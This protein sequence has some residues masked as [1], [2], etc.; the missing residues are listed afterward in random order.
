[1]I[2]LKV[3]LDKH[4]YSSKNRLDMFSNS[5]MKYK[6]YGYSLKPNL[7]EDMALLQSYKGILEDELLNHTLGGK[8]CLYSKDLQ[9]LLEKVSR[10]TVS[11]NI[12]QR[13][14]LKIFSTQESRDKWVAQNPH[15][16]SR[17]RWEKLA[18]IVCDSINLDLTVI[19]N[20]MMCDITFELIR[21]IISC[22]L[23][24]ALSVREEACDLNLEVSRSEKECEIDFKLL[25]ESIDCNLTL[26][27][28]KKLVANNFTYDII[29]TVYENGCTLEIGDTIEL[30]TPI[31][32]YNVNN[33]KFN[34][35][36]DFSYVGRIG[37]NLNNSK[38]IKDPHKFINKLK[39]DYG[40]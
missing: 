33:I 16:V 17:E 4:I 13:K 7:I 6:Y 5:L 18:Y 8:G 2:D 3:K 28:Y 9:S 12:E 29:Y 10:L 25:K 38:Y 20:T 21:D 22:D 37:S 31:N 14:D 24:V 34:S 40:E 19:D 30:V 39:Q 26:E 11:C 1:M 15:C 35:N 36:P 32:R 23:M 27:S